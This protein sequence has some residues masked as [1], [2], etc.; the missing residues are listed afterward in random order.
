MYWTNTKLTWHQKTG[1]EAIFDPFATAAT[2]AV[3]RWRYSVFKHN[4]Y[5]AFDI[6]LLSLPSPDHHCA[7]TD[8]LN[9][10]RVWTTGS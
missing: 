2:T 9:D 6:S 5:F 8:E 3:I 1:G 4:A 7:E 10:A